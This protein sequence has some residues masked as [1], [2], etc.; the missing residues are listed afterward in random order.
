MTETTI[1]TETG[2]AVGGSGVVGFE[3]GNNGVANRAALQGAIDALGAAGG[4]VRVERAGVYDLA[5]TVYMGS[6]TALVFGAGVIVRKTEEAGGFSHVILNKGALTKTWDR[7]VRVEGLRLMV[8]GVDVRS[9]TV[10]GLRGQ[11][12]FFYASDVRVIGL[13]CDDLGPQQFGVHVCTFEDLVV[14]DCIIKGDKDGVHLGRGKRFAVRGCVFQTRDDAVAL[15]AHDY[16]TSNPELGWIEQG[17]VERCYDLAAPAGKAHESVGYFC[18]VLAGSWGDWR[19][20]MSVQQSDTVVMRGDGLPGGGRL[21]RVQAEPDG[22]RYVSRTC[23]SHDAGV[24]VVDGIP[25]LMMQEGVEASAGVRDVVFRD[26][27]LEKP[28]PGFSVHFDRD[29]Y[30]RS[31]YPGSEPPVQRGLVMEDVRVFHGGDSPVLLI[32]TPVDV[33]TLSRVTLGAGGVLVHDK[34]EVGADG[35]EST[36]TTVQLEGCRYV[37]EGEMDLLEQRWAGKRVRLTTR[38]SVVMAEGFKARVARGQGVGAVD[39]ESD[40]PGLARH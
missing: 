24:E 38:G 2:P 7:R 32:G 15:N 11:V 19:G 30:S 21:Y 18:R 37:R 14:E 28:R 31:Y 36:Q 6:D 27:T 4:T 16:A 39:V 9:D 25:W 22:T 5:G 29:R 12:A 3:P 17:V 40:L 26:I 8:N 33:V 20:G 23:P 1:N 35:R 34:G 10:P 13:R